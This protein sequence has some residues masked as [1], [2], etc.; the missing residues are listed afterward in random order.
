MEKKETIKSVTFIIAGALLQIFN[1]IGGGWAAPLVSIFGLILFFIG[2]RKLKDGLDPAGQG[3]VRMLIIAAIFGLVGLFFDLIPLMGWLAVI[4]FIVAFVIELIG[5][6]KLKSSE[7]IGEI[8]KKGAGLLLIS[9]ILVI[10]ANLFDFIPFLGFIASLFSLVALYL[11]F[12]GWVKIQSGII[13]EN[14]SS[15]KSI[16][17][18]IV[19]TL[20]LLANAATSGWAAAIASIFGLVMLLKGFNLLNDEVDEKGKES[21][22]LLVISVYV[23]LAASALDFIASIMSLGK[24]FMDSLAT[25]DIIVILVFVGAYVLQFMAYLKLKESSSIG[26]SGK[27]GVLFLMIAMAVSIVGSFLGFIPLAG[28][29]TPVFAIVGLIL[30]FFGW[31]KIQEGI[32]KV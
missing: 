18:I 9:M 14:Q 19:G 30:V 29:V 5:F 13:G 15:V 6:I 4:I 26:E 23:G 20:L 1:G 10:V 32:I 2:L 12:A 3:A 16:T 25:F 27:K 24:G 28:L 17:Y 31:V 21:V 8:G 11:V 7:S 22:K